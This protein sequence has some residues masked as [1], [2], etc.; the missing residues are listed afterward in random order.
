[1]GSRRKA[2]NRCVQ[3]G[4]GSRLENNRT[5]KIVP[6]PSPVVDSAEATSTASPSNAFVSDSVFPYMPNYVSPSTSDFVPPF[7]FDSASPP[8][9]T[10]TPTPPPTLTPSSHVNSVNAWPIKPMISLKQS[11]QTRMR[12][13]RSWRGTPAETA[14]L[15]SR[16][17]A[18]EVTQRNCRRFH[19][20]S[21]MR[22]RRLFFRNRRRSKRNFW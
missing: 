22:R 16:T 10:P 11:L 18:L 2:D 14:T 21:I 8:S 9:P 19:P 1:M 15:P 6:P 3:R 17:S 13:Q 4:Q 20:T 7:T 5:R 12:D